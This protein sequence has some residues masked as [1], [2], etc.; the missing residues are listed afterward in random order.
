MNTGVK[1]PS[2]PTWTSKHDLKTLQEK[3][4]DEATFN[5]GYR[6]MAVSPGELKFPSWQSCY[7]RGVTLSDLRRRG[8]P[9]YVGVDLSSP[10]RP[11]NAI[12]RVGL[13]PQTNY[14]VLLGVRFGKWTSPQTARALAEECEGANVQYIQVENNAY[15]DSLIDWIKSEKV[16]FPFWMK[17]EPFTT[18]TNKADPQFG[19]PGLEVEFHNKGWI[20]PYEQWEGHPASCA[21]DWCHLDREMRL[22]P[23]GATFDGGM[24]LWFARDA[25]N[26]WAPRPGATGSGN[27]GRLNMR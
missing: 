1:L 13:E 11:G 16:N 14:R 6:M 18:G 21:C 23:R 19:L 15:Q 5:R 24:A 26:K 12:V 27:L 10:R 25:L 22:Y 17:I 20:L 3:A 8:L 9:E 7:A 2:I 4:V